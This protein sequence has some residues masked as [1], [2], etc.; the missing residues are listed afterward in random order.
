MANERAGVEITAKTVEEAIERGLRELGASRDEVE[1][2]VLDAGRGGLLG[3]GAHQA[4]VRLTKTSATEP[5]AEVLDITDARAE[6]PLVAGALA[7][8][9]ESASLAVGLLQGLIDR[10]GVHGKVVARTSDELVE[11]GET[12]ALVLDVM[13]K[14]LGVLIG[15]QAETL[16]AMQYLIRLMLSKSL[17]RWEPVVVDV[18]S[19]RARRR[20]SLRRLAQRMAERAASS[21]RRVILEAM[22]A[23]ER[24][25]VHLALHDH[26]S[27]TT[28]SIGEG[29]HR[30]VTIIPQ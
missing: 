4:Q 22:P 28:K 30:K 9:S 24:R 10:M 19:Y 11:E 12:P 16:Q 18:E 5:P 15:R 26:P 25:I 3:L 29:D 14:D 13:G 8:P 2:E 6:Q 23:H 17:G 20:R 27:V 1:I 7:P 21:R